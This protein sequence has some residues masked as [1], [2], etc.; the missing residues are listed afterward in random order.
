VLGPC[1][2]VHGADYSVS[3]RR[4]TLRASCTGASPLDGLATAAI[5]GVYSDPGRPT[6]GLYHQI[7]P[8]GTTLRIQRRIAGGEG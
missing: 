4:T 1:I 2:G 8:G 5:H 7:D 3:A 6:R